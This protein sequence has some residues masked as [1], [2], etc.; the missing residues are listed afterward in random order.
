M[1]QDQKSRE[2]FASRTW[3]SFEAMIDAHAA[4]AVKV[5][6]ADFREELPYAPDS[7]E[8]LEIILNR[9]SPAPSPLAPEDGDWW[10][11]LWGCWFGEW[12]RQAY[13]GAWEMS[14]YPGTQFSAPTLII[15]GARI[16]PT[17]KVHRRLSLGASES[18]PEFYVKAQPR[19][20]AAIRA[21]AAM[22][23]EDAK[24]N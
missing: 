21:A 11:L 2:R 13:G 5:A 15:A 18:L 1:Q 3:D 12:L 23:E 17:V 24:P 14:V 16:Y 9:L 6:K 7:L 22:P 4:E 8:R 20:E 19:L 10:S